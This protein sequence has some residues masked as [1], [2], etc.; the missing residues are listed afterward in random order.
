MITQE[1]AKDFI[2]RYPKLKEGYTLKRQLLRGGIMWTA[3]TMLV[4]LLL[5]VSSIIDP[6][7]GTAMLFT[8]Y[9]TLL[10]VP[11]AT[12]L[13]LMLLRRGVIRAKSNS[14]VHK[15]KTTGVAGAFGALGGSLGFVVFRLFPP[16]ENAVA[17][18]FLPISIALVA[19]VFNYIT[20]HYFYQL[21]L[22]L[23]HCPE[24]AD[25]VDMDMLR[26]KYKA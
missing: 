3:A 19:L 14:G 20:T 21:Y 15:N 22:L 13:A 16:A 24:F 17:A 5:W 2:L 4:I 18:L 1:M 9:A 11:V 6:Q 25:E 23:K 8:L 26:E 12:I 7:L 10:L